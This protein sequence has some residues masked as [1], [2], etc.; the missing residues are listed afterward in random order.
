MTRDAHRKRQ[1]VIGV[2]VDAVTWDCAIRRVM[3]WAAERTSR[4]V[5]VTN[6][7]VVVTAALDSDFCRVVSDADLAVPDG[8]PVAWRMR[9]L[10]SRGQERIAGPDLMVALLHA[11]EAEKVAVY[12]YGS[13]SEVLQRMA[14]R[15][16]QEFPKLT[17]GGMESPPF[18]ELTGDEDKSA[19]ERINASGAGLVFVGLGCP[20][21]EKW[22]AEHR[23]Q[24]GATMLGVG[25]AFDFYAGTLP[26]APLLMRRLGLEWLHRFAHSPRRLGKRYLLTNCY[27]VLA[28]LREICFGARK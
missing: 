11:A 7:H 8:A 17:V 12:F 21:Q 10:G 3:D 24:V 9:T 23:G 2:P 5:A 28:V 22:M 1:P 14:K 19:C 6:V 20:K 27:F 18:R 15:L 25:A 4:Y 16:T 13:T 26:R